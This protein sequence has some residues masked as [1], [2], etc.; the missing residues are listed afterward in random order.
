MKIAS[1]VSIV[2]VIDTV[3]HVGLFLNGKLIMSRKEEDGPAREIMRDI[4]NNLEEYTGRQAIM[5]E[6]Q[7]RGAPWTWDEVI[8]SIKKSDDFGRKGQDADAMLVSVDGGQTYSKA[9]EGVRI[10]YPNR[11]LDDDKIAE[12]Q[13]NATQE[14]MIFDAWEGCAGGR[15]DTHAGTMAEEID[16]LI[17]SC[18]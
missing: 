3:N 11:F 18:Q 15:L 7:K 10:I 4:A 6:Y 17:A 2:R 13:V 16:D 9:V 8:E 1:Q 14:G 5:G 12:L